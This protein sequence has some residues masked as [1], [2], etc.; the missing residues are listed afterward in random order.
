V[1]MHPDKKFHFNWNITKNDESAKVIHYTVRIQLCY[2][3]NLPDEAMKYLQLADQFINKMNVLV[4]TPEYYFYQTL[5]L[6]RF[7]EG[8]S[9]FEKSSARRKMVRNLKLME[10]W[11]KHSPQNYKH[12]LL[13][14]KARYQDLLQK[15][16]IIVI[17]KQYAEAIQNAKD[18]GYLQ[19]AAIISECAAQF[20]SQQHLESLAA[21]YWKEAY[22]LYKS[23]G[24]E[25]KAKEIEGKKAAKQQNAVYFEKNKATFDFESIMKAANAL[26]REIVYEKLIQKMMVI[27]MENAGA[28]RGY[29]FVVNKQKL[30]L[31][32]QGDAKLGCTIKDNLDLKSLRGEVAV[33][34]IKYVSITL[35]PLVLADARKNNL[36]YKE[37][38]IV[39]KQPKSVLTF[40]I[41]HQNQ[42]IAVLYFENNLMTHAFT[43]ERIEVLSLLASQAAI[44][45]KNAQI[46]TSLE[47]KVKERTEALEQ[48]NKSLSLAN[49]QLEKEETL[50]KELFSN[51]SHDLRSPITS[52][53]GYMEAVIDGV[54]ANP[55][56]QLNYLKR[57]LNRTRG[58]S[59]LI[60][61]I[62]DL[63]Q[64]ETG[65]MRFSYEWIT[66]SDLWKH[67]IH[68]FEIE[69]RR[70][71]L[72]FHAGVIG[73]ELF[74]LYIDVDRID[75][76][77][78]NLISNALKFTSKGSITL[79][80]NTQI[81]PGF[82]ICSITDTGT[83]MEQEELEVIFERKYTK[84]RNG[85]AEGN[86][87]GLAICKE[88]IAAHK[89]DIWAESVSGKGTTM[90]FSLPVMK[91][92][93][94][95]QEKDMQLPV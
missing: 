28:E 88:I 91:K 3:L 83:G 56:D 17:E 16:D 71:D 40:P 61:Q 62:F 82:L 84:R 95:E 50:K 46:Y 37:D 74:S 8:M 51:I 6:T 26:S 45:I 64:L 21:Y 13:A 36:F 48:V 31:A 12:K 53:Q 32:V 85:S 55:E 86:G 54:I 34:M 59:S 9:A 76:V 22:E 93:H 68:Q 49:K 67:W 10:R 25:R 11:A 41:L 44:S 14:M 29:L 4:I 92:T 60:Q 78:T 73:D 7:Y 75:R 87:L 57:A 79:T 89:G 52:I 47:E 80:V 42:L 39:K 43:S 20:F 19:D 63:S 30:Q 27:L 69:I 81:K 23:W 5:W 65:S 35:E 66:F 70:A 94:E 1:L 15:K 77:L 2:L 72:N 38:Y 58:L 33:E 18:N 24:A 90:S